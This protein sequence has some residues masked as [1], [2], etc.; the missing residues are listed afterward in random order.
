MLFSKIQYFK[1]TFWY[2]PSLLYL[3]VRELLPLRLTDSDG[4]QHSGELEPVLGTVDELG[5][6]SQ[7]AAL[8][9]V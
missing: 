6:S 7:D 9:T 3:S 2:K 5:R 1:N 8:L 4:V